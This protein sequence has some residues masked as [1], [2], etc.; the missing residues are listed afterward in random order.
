MLLDITGTKITI[1]RQCELVGISRSTAYYKPYINPDDLKIMNE[2][3]LI[4]N[5]WPFYGKRKMAKELNKREIDIGI[6]KTRKLMQK[7][8]LEVV[9]PKQK[10]SIKNNEHKI[11]PYLLKDFEINRSNQ[12]WGTD[13]T[14][15]RL[16]EGFIYLVAIID[17]YSRYVLAWDISMTMESKFCTETLEKALMVAKPQIFNSD[18]G[19]Q[20]T[21]MDFTKILE[22]N[23]VKI[24][25]DGRGRCM[26]NIFTERLWRT[27]KYEEVYLKDY[28]SPL[29]AYKGL[30]DYFNFYNNERIHQSLNYET[31]AKIYYQKTIS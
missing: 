11:Y 24:S 1:K 8:G 9:Y 23:G 6:K 3:D 18:Q 14:Y 21:S 5:K 12:V 16:A 19:S 31:P 20:F 2:I 17:W 13:I 26:D 27:V 29:D 7:M 22:E 15:I 28:A 4:Y 30:K 25:M 10:T